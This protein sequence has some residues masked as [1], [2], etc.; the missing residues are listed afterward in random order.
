VRFVALAFMVV[1]TPAFAERY[2]DI[3]GG[4][5]YTPQSDITLVVGS[6]SGPADTGTPIFT[7]SR[8]CKARSPAP[9]C[10]RNSTSTPTTSS[11]ASP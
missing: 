8:R 5:A 11:P 4:A 2:A 6:P 3:Y 7:Q 9:A 10:R 1:A